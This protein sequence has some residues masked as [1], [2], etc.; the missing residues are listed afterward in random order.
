MADSAKSLYDEDYH[1]WVAS[2]AD[3]LRRLAENR[4][5]GPLDLEHLAEEVEDLG[6]TERNAVLSQA[7]RVIG[8]ALKLE[9]SQAAEPR[10]QWILSVAEARRELARHLTRS[11]RRVLEDELPV[12]YRSERDLT[13]RALRLYGEPDA[14]A[15]LPADCPYTLEQILDP[16][17]FPTN[18]HGLTE[19]S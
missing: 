3:A 12:S 11:L 4:W 1:A 19:P 18:R 5:N 7:E 14:A 8:H 6:K 15:A 17:W 2:Q 16:D 9:H 13:A 10:R